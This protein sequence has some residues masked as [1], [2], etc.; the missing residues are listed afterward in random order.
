MIIKSN[1]SCKHTDLEVTNIYIPCYCMVDEKSCKVKISKD[2]T[3]F[4]VDEEKHS[5][6]EAIE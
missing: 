1:R 2:N 5:I 6:D 3:F 4:H